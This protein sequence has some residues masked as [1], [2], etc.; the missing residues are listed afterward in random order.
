MYFIVAYHFTVHIVIET[1]IIFMAVG[2]ASQL[3]AQ[4]PYADAL[5]AGAAVPV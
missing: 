2:Q 4:L 3:V 1:L 5:A